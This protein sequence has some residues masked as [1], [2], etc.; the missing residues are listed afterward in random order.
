VSGIPPEPDIMDE[1]HGGSAQAEDG[2]VLTD[3]FVYEVE[4]ALEAEDAK[5]VNELLQALHVADLADLLEYLTRDE[6][7]QAIEILGARLEPEALAYLDPAVREE[8]IEQLGPRGQL[9][10]MLTGFCSK[11]A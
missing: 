8:V 5:R 2:Y 11:R 4:D 7:H 6:R 10:Q 3:E 1:P 9:C